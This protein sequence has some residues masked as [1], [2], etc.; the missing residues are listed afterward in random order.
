MPRER[1]F[2]GGDEESPAEPQRPD[3][4]MIRSKGWR[5]D[6]DIRDPLLHVRIREKGFLTFLASLATGCADL[7]I[8]YAVRPVE[9]FTLKR[10]NPFELGGVEIEVLPCADREAPQTAVRRAGESAFWDNGRKCPYL[11]FRVRG[12]RAESDC[13]LVLA[14][15][16]LPWRSGWCSPGTVSLE[17]VS[18]KWEGDAVRESLRVSHRGDEIA[19]IQKSWRDSERQSGIEWTIHFTQP[20]DDLR[21][22]LLVLLTPWFCER[23]QG[24]SD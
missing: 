8:E 5:S 12:Q 23:L 21:I 11:L 6:V 10:A 2:V 1:P 3:A 16:S 18:V 4:V 24:G 7:G 14:A 13:G 17:T 19:L 9:G 22:R 15:S 20:T